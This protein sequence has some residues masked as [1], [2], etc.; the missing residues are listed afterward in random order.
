MLISLGNTASVV[1]L[2]YLLSAAE[3]ETQARSKRQVNMESS[4]HG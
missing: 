4:S 2:I 3:K 1:V